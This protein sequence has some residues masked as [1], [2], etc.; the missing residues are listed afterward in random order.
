M[1]SIK[2]SY[3]HQLPMDIKNPFDESGKL[4]SR[5]VGCNCGY[6]RNAFES[7]YLI[8]GKSVLLRMFK[9]NGV[10]T[11]IGCI[12]ENIEEMQAWIDEVVEEE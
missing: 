10:Q 4:L 2:E 12:K 3:V 8:R 11:C 5:W 9:V 1:I 6:E 7:N